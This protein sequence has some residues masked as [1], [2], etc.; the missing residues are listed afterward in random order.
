MKNTILFGAGQAGAMVLKLLSG[1]YLPVCF[2][3]NSLEK[4]KT[5]HC[6]FPVLPLSE[7]LKTEPDCVCICALDDV[8]TA[9]ME[10]QLRD[11]GFSGDIFYARSLLNFDIRAA[12]MRL[13]ADEIKQNDIS[14]DIAELGVYKGDFAELINLSFPERRLHLFDT[15][16]GFPEQDALT[17]R[18]MGFSKAQTGDFSETGEVFVLSRMSCLDNVIIHKG[19]FPE[20]FSTCLDI[21]F[22]F[23]S[24]DADLYSPT[25]AALP[26]FWDRLSIG[27]AI[28]IH[29]YNSTQFSGAGLAVREFCKKRGLYP[30]PL[31]DLH[32]SAVLMKTG[33]F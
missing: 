5:V 29:D 24:I 2:A 7:A 1:E 16:S 22:A 19:Y 28:I 33:G 11:L 27:G 25:E 31:S 26:L 15:F 6:G 18:S 32:G 13:I 17:D 23:V 14:G 21:S 10:N 9:Q 3:D 30:V 4:Q 12:T 20:T 8:R